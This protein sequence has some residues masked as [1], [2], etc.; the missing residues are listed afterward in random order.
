[1]RR[2]SIQEVVLNETSG[3]TI[4]TG[5]QQ[6]SVNEES[7]VVASSQEVSVN[8]TKTVTSEAGGQLHQTAGQTLSAETEP[9][10]LLVSL[11][12]LG[13]LPKAKE[14]TI[15]YSKPVDSTSRLYPFAHAIQRRFI[16]AGFMQQDMT[17]AF[18]GP[19]KGQLVSRPLLLHAT[20]A[21]TI[22]APKKWKKPM[23]TEE[24]NNGQKNFRPKK[25]TVKI[26]SVPLLQELAGPKEGEG[27]H[28]TK[29]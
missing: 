6:L 7:G 24:N 1:M 10:P 14:A 11:T 19:Q 17:K 29:Q 21:N 26:N 28:N 4:E 3:R 8:K 5:T 22:Y 9:E 16:E 12:S 13:A 18:T 23:R 20:M 27:E 2:S 15:L 25:E